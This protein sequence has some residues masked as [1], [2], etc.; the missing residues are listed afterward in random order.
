ES[1][2]TAAIVFVLVIFMLLE[3]ED[4]R[5]RFLRLSGYKR[6]AAT[7]RALDEAGQRITRYLQMQTLLNTSLGLGIA[8]GLL[9]IGVPYALLWGFLA[10]VLR[11]IPY[12]GPWLAGLGL[13]AFCLAAFAEW[14]PSLVVIGL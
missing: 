9:L 13:A 11:F 2:G 7:T 8:I 12:V 14:W 4:L 1:F 6:L 5:N 3:R 10:A